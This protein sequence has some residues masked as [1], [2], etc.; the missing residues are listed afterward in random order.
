MILW[1]SSNLFQRFML[2]KMRVEACKPQ[3]PC[4]DRHHLR[5]YKHS[6]DIFPRTQSENEFL[7]PLPLWWLPVFLPW[8][9]LR[10]SCISLN[11][12]AVLGTA[13]PF[14]WKR[15]IL[16][17]TGNG[18]GGTFVTLPLD[19]LRFFAA[20]RARWSDSRLIWSHS[21]EI[22]VLGPFGFK[23]KKKAKMMRC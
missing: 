10:N 4:I 21:L 11:R 14:S 15:D 5:L 1:F 12:S 6:P 22:T 23:T 20:A 7:F 19:P 2:A 13:L 8:L 9:L 18:R 16:T 17:L 3:I